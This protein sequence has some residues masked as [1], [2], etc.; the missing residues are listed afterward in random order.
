MADWK[1][2]WEKAIGS[3]IKGP[4]LQTYD[5]TAMQKAIQYINSAQSSMRQAAK[6][7]DQI[8]LDK[9]AGKTKTSM[10]KLITSNKSTISSTEKQLDVCEQ[11]LL[12]KIKAIG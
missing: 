3:V 11:T 8:N 10:L 9:L 7:L 4:D 1:N 2:G 5:S 12:N 6:E